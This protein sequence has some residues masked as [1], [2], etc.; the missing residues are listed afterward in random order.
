M[1]EPQN[2]DEFLTKSILEYARENSLKFHSLNR[3]I[4]KGFEQGKREFRLVVSDNGDAYVHP[5][6]KDGETHDLKF[7]IT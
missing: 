6:W 3:Y 4:N 5:L 2:F 7:N 1:K